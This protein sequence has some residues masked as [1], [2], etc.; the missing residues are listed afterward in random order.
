MDTPDYSYPWYAKL[1][2]GGIAVFGVTAFLTAELAEDGAGTPG[3]LL[4]AWLGLSLAGFMLMRGLGGV[5]GG[6]PLRF[7]GWSP[8]ARRQWRLARADLAALARLR[9]PDRGMHEGL[10][11]LTQAFGLALFAWMGATGAGMFALGGGPETTMF[12]LVEEVHE[13]GETLIPLYLCL[14]AGSVVLHGLAGH[15]VWRRMWAV[16][17]AGLESCADEQT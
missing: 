14:H 15:P 1:L 16:N 8:F 17:R 4:H 9:M 6:G 12:E 13:L 10:A 11:G 3:Y 7:S 5:A 2:H